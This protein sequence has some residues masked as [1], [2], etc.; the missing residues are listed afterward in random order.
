LTPKGIRS[1]TR[2]P[3]NANTIALLDQ[4]GSLMGD[5]GRETAGDSGIPAGFTY[6]GQFVDHDITLDVSSSLDALANAENIP[7]MRT[8]VLD[9]DSVYGMVPHCAPSCM[10]RTTWST[11]NGDQVASRI[12]PEFRPWRFKR[13]WHTGWHEDS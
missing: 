1:A 4:L 5:A 11:V 6:V 13:K 7:N 9:L 8:P 10:C 3:F 2:V 12:K